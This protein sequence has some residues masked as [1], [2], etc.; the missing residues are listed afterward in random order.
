MKRPVGEGMTRDA[1]TLLFEHMYRSFFEGE[2]GKNP[3]STVSPEFLRKI[4]F[5]IANSF[6]HYEVFPVK[7]CKDILFGTV[8]SSDLLSSFGN[9]LPNKETSIVQQFIQGS[10]ADVPAIIDILSENKIFVY[11]T[12]VEN[13]DRFLLQAPE[14]TLLRVTHFSFQILVQGMEDLWKEINEEII[15]FIY[16]SATPDSPRITAALDVLEEQPY[17]QKLCTWLHRYIGAST[18]QAFIQALLPTAAFTQRLS[19]FAVC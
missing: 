15:D 19:F 8:N 6:I 18:Q 12:T 14:I 7:L 2:N 16:N 17:D 5:I 13:I 3:L 4:G 1:Y 10:N 9:Y 11:P